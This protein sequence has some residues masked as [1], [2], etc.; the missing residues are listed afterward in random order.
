MVDIHCHIFPYI[1]DGP[2]DLSEFRDLANEAVKSGITHLYAT[3]HHLNG[4]YENPKRKILE[5]LHEYNQYLQKYNIPLE[6]HCG[7]ELRIH[8]DIFHTIKRD[9]VLTLDNEGKYLLL[10]LPSVEV[11]FNT[12]EVVYE[13]LLMGITPIIVH[14]ERNIEFIHDLNL[15]FN[16]VQEGALTQLTAGSIIGHF[17]KKIK[18]ASEK[19]IEHQLAHFIASD[20]HNTHSRSFFLREA[21]EMVTR[22]KGIQQTYFFQE[23]A[24]LIVSMQTPMR[25][26]PIP[27]R[28]KIFGFL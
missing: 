21:Y 25:E 11:P 15:L 9:E 19:I 28:K 26:Q 2:C 22:T 13:L 3:P 23:N 12:H 4:K 17:G 20:A 24:N 5:S 18:L 10:E 16:L 7:Q 6:I 27:I 8:H 14:P 1:D